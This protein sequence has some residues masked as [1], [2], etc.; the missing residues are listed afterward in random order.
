MAQVIPA[1]YGFDIFVGI[2]DSKSKLSFTVMNELSL[3]SSKTIPSDPENVYNYMRRHFPDKRALYAYEAGPTGFR[4]YDYLTAK[5]ECCFVVSPA[6]LLKAANQRV[7]NNRIDS[8]KIASQLKAGELH[9]I[10]IPEGPYREVRY[11]IE[12]REN[13]AQN[14]RAAK[15]RI[16]SLLLYTGLHT[17]LP[18]T[19][20]RWSNHY[21]CL[22]KELSCSEIMRQKLNMLLADLAYF[23]AQA[24]VV[25]R[26]LRNFCQ[27][28]EEINEYRNYLQ[29]IPG[30]GL[31]TSLTILARIGDP[32]NLRNPRELAAFAGL[33]PT[34]KSTGD[35]IQH[36]SITHLG[37][38]ML[39][40]ALI[41]AAWVAIRGD[42]ELRQ[43]YE[44]I[45]SRHHPGIGAQKAIVAVARKLTQRIYCV[46]KEKRNYTV[47]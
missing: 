31:I 13:Y 23:R 11:L 41:E 20:M 25:L 29:S 28:H 12:L 3:I 16:K 26:Q 42:T 39:R 15:Q 1:A 8:L 43:F 4:L 38:P 14:Q 46:L 2:D 45:R 33:V 7:K 6:S 18:D 36:G 27:R 35:S 24:L 44:R 34:E 37:N 10:R 9:S 17:C 47:H 30:I 19:D 21:L 5:G 22:L 40:S 32:R